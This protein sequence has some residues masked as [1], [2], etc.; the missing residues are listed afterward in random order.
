VTRSSS[1]TR[2]AAAVASL[3]L[4]ACSHG[5]RP[6]VVVVTLDTVRADH[7][8]CY[9]SG[10]GTTPALDRLSAAGVLFEDASCAV[11]LT[12]PSHATLFTGRYPTAT[13]V[14][15]NGTFVLPDSETTLAERLA[16]AGYATGAVIA[17]FPLQ[18]RY[19]L[20]QG[21]RIY[22]EELPRRAADAGA[23]FSIHFNERNAQAVTDRAIEV[24]K[25]LGSGPRFLWV[26][27]FDAHAPYEAPEPWG[28]A[29]AASPYDGEI[30]FVDDQAGRLLTRIG[31]DAPGAIVV[32]AGDHG[33][34]LGEHGEK[35]HGVFLYQSTL[36][37][38]L[39][40]VAPGRWPAGGRVAVPVSLAD[41][42]PTILALSGVE[43]ASGL[44]GVDL[45]PAVAGRALPRREVYAES[46]LPKLQFRFSALT[47][48][49]DGPL[50]YID[51]PTAELYDLARDPGER[52]NVAARDAR[53]TALASRLAT[54]AAA[55]DP[56]AS[57]RSTS[58]LDADAD[59]R[60]RSLGYASAGT[61]AAGSE[62]RG[63]DPKTM[64]GYL[65][66]YDRAVGLASSG[67]VDEGVRELRALLPE[68]PENFMVRYQV[69]AAL[70][71]SG[72][73]EEA[74]S[75]LAQVVAAAPEFG[76][77]YWMLGDA[78]AAVGRL[79]EAMTAYADSA[80]R[81][82]NQAGP[83]IAAGHAE[84]SRGRFDAAAER[85]RAAIEAE[86]ASA[87][88][89]HALSA[90]YAGRG[91][92]ARAVTDLGALLDRHPA[93]APL[94][95][96]LADAQY[97]TADAPAAARTLRRALTLE[98]SRPEAKVLEA[99]ML[100]DAGHPSEAA[101]IYRQ[102]LAARPDNRAAALGLG[103]ALALGPPDAAAQEWIDGL[104][105]RFPSDAAPLVSRGVL[106][107]RRGDAGGA[108]E[109][110]RRALALNPRDPDAR[111]GI[112]RLVGHA[113]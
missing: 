71:A 76:N 74:R 89:A 33:E 26:H 21:F 109:A 15:N 84:E 53:A 1:V 103:R 40:I 99:T 5:G 93:S 62:G 8:G 75:E 105:T 12:L 51:A 104:A 29:H 56:E 2:I 70:L 24:W 32:V 25:R 85:F 80:R 110:Y 60:L 23:A 96:A 38:P 69:A 111:R 52:E 19:G 79:D 57:A 3:T 11:P 14:R 102:V 54:L 9:G 48:L 78:L 100:L 95:V 39:I 34:G 112:E 59:A 67:R 66:R 86:P 87:A 55:A 37:V 42:V 6:D 83:W 45:A 88:A 18:S 90:L 91:E 47:M 28:S 108:L 113:P 31:Q 77:A 46:Y 101:A 44:D 73:A 41:V 50:K 82:P 7:L 16:A 13:G 49:R 72:H 27:Y 10:T 107:E 30:A 35:T 58:A 94:A 106:L 97:R 22:D 61:L 65:E 17:A 81:L 68:A 64:T 63:R 20:A 92:L 43:R 98:P 36:H 4:A